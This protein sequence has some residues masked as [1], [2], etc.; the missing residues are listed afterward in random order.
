MRLYLL[1]DNGDVRSTWTRVRLPIPP[2]PRAAAVEVT[3]VCPKCGTTPFLVNGAHRR[4]ATDDR[5]YEADAWALCCN[6]PV[7]IL[8]QEV[9][10]IFGLQEDEE[11][12]RAAARMRAKMYGP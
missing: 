5:A 4:I 10:T 11:T 3:E 8:R 6:E 2:D 7:G 12:L 9:D 1:L